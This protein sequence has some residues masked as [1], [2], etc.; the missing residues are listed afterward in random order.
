MSCRRCRIPIDDEGMVKVG[1]LRVKFQYLVQSLAQDGT[2]PLT[3]VRGG[4]SLPIRL[5]VR[6]SRPLLIRDLNGGYLPYFICG[7]LTFAPAT[8]EL[9]APLMRAANAA[10]ALSL[11]G[12][13]MLGRRS[14]LPPTPGEE[15]VI[16]SATPFPS[17]LMQGYNKPAFSAVRSVN[18]VEIHNLKQL[19]VLLRDSKDEFLDFEFYGRSSQSLILPRQETLDSTNDILSDNGV[20]SQGS[21][22]MME[23]WNAKKTAP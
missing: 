6:F 5:P 4:Q 9:V 14:E 23:V 10:N 20:R 16:V 7:P 8:A 17:P 1:D 3:V 2:V 15:L 21:Q 12:N 13:P 19:V 22:D 18:G 11:T